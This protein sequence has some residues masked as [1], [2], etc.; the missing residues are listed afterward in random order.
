MKK[1][2][3]FLALIISAN[4]YAQM[5]QGGGGRG[6]Q[7]GFGGPGGGRRGGPPSEG[8]GEF[9]RF[10]ADETPVLEFFPE[11]PNLT[12]E[13]RMDVGNILIDEQKSIRKNESQK[14]E[15]MKK[16]RDATDWDEK[17]IEKNRKKIADI[18][19]KNGTVI[20]KSNKKIKKKLSDEQ[21]QAFL[22]KRN[23][24]RF[25]SQQPPRRPEGRE[26][27]N[28]EGM[29]RPEGRPEFQQ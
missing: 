21:Y 29:P 19:K 24:F 4:I 20:E 5:P 25:K 9:N 10:N 16:E 7:G 23:E 28:R 11:I 6:G 18:D 15:L 22:E 13:Q 12:L 1:V 8:R 27:G 3:I 17:K 26:G 14:H 2:I